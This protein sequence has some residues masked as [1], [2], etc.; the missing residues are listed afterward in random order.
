MTEQL[1]VW[2]PILPPTANK[3][4]VRGSI[5]KPEARQY[6][7]EFKKFLQDKYGHVIQ[8]LPDPNKDPNIVFKLV[9]VMYMNCLN[10]GWDNPEVKD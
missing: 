5:L 9:L 6:R 3:I 7:E 8:E 4:Y 10:E 2:Y 1:D